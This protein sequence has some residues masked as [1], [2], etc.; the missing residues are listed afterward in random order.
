MTE[1]LN[2]DGSINENWLA[3]EI[4]RR[5]KGLKEVDIG[6]VKEVLKVTLDILTEIRNESDEGADKFDEL[7]ERHRT[8]E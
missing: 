7:L 3:E 4:T 8:S 6:Q 2:Q 5:E 1:K